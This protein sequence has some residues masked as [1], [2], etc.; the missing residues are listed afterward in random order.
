MLGHVAKRLN[1]DFGYLLRNT[2][3]KCSHSERFQLTAVKGKGQKRIQA[4]SE[5]YG[6]TFECATKEEAATPANCLQW[7]RLL[8]RGCVDD[9]YF[10]P[11]ASVTVKVGSNR[12][13]W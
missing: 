3:R 2:A 11:R 13:C 9:E 8:L 1:E 4:Y 10:H 7:A 6:L 5:T 12:P